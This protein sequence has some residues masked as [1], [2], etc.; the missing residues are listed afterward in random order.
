MKIRNRSSSSRGARAARMVPVVTLLMSGLGLVSPAH[1]R[2]FPGAGESTTQDG[3]EDRGVLGQMVEKFYQQVT[4]P[5]GPD[6]DPFIGEGEIQGKKI[7]DGRF[8]LLESKVHLQGMEYDSWTIL[9]YDPRSNSYS[10]TALDNGSNSTLTATGTYDPE[11]SMLEFV[12]ERP[13]AA[14]QVPSRFRFRYQFLDKDTVE[15]TFQ[16]E[17]ADAPTV[18]VYR[19]KLLKQ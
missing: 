7:M 4:I 1:V 2:A 9:G 15:V 3:A 8:V 14:A 10:L 6:L 12:G 16:F 11:T 18:E 5:R 17:F 13:D 19:A